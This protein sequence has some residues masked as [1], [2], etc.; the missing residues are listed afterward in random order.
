MKTIKFFVF[1][2]AISCL[3][4]SCNNDDLPSELEKGIYLQI[5]PTYNSYVAENGNHYPSLK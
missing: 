5:D 1:V 2:C 4:V 3:F